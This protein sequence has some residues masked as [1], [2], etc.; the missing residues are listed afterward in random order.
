MASIHQDN[1]DVLSQPHPRATQLHDNGDLVN[2]ATMSSGGTDHPCPPPEARVDA[3]L[4]QAEIDSKKRKTPSVD[5]FV[6]IKKAK[7]TEGSGQSS[8]SPSSLQ[9]PAEV[10]QHIFTFLQPK[11]LGRLL[12]VSRAFNSLLDSSSGHSP[13]ARLSLDTGSLPDLKPEIIWQLSRRR[14]W[15]TMPTPLRGYTELQMWQL[16]C[17]KKCQFHNGIG[18]LVSSHSDSSQYVDEKHDSSQPIW[19][20]ALNSCRPCLMKRITK[21][22]DLL[23]SS[24][25]PSC[26]I[27]ALPFIF[28]GDDMRVILP[29][30]LQAGSLAAP[31]SITKVFLSSHV[32]AI[33][34]EFASVTAMGE[35]TAEEWIKGLEGRGKEHRADSL[36]WERFEISGTFS[37]ILNRLSSDCGQE[38]QIPDE[39]VK[40]RLPTTVAPIGE[41][42]ESLDFQEKIAPAKNNIASSTQLLGSSQNSV[43]PSAPEHYSCSQATIQ[44]GRTREEAEEMKNARRAEIERRAKKLDPPLLPHALALIPSFQA[45]IQITSPFDDTA[46]NVLKPRLL[47]Q[48]K[49]VQR[50]QD[51]RQETSAHAQDTLQHLE[52]SQIPQKLPLET[53]QKLDHDWDDAQAPLRGHISALADFVI[54]E[55]WKN[56]RKVN[57]ESS[58]RFA[59]EVL[60][61]VRKR[62]YAEIEKDDAASRAAGQQPIRDA[63]NG[64][65]TRKLTLENMKW[66]FDVKIKPHT[67]QY[68]RELFYCHVCGFNT[69]L[70][71]LEGVVQHY[72]AKHTSSLSLGNVVVHWRAEWP[73]V[74]PF[75]PE[76]HNLKH[77]RTRSFHHNEAMQNYGRPMP[78]VRYEA[79][80]AQSLY[81]QSHP[82]IAPM[83]EYASPFE[84]HALHHPLNPPL[85]EPTYER[86]GVSQGAVSYLPP[87]PTAPANFHQSHYHMPYQN[88]PTQEAQ[89]PYAQLPNVYHAKLEDISQNAKKIWFTMA[90]MRQLPGPIKM[91]VLIHH[92]CARFRTR[93]SEELPLALFIDGLSTNK[94]MHPLRIINGLRCKAC[95]L[96]LGA[97]TEA[98]QEKDTYSLLQLVRH[99]QDRHL[100]Q[101][102]PDGTPILNWAYDMI[103]LVD[104]SIL[105]NLSSLRNI[106]NWKLSLIRAAF[107]G[108]DFGNSGTAIR[109]SVSKANHQ[110]TKK[111]S[112]DTTMITSNTNART[113]VE[114]PPP[115]CREI[116]QRSSRLSPQSKAENDEK[117][118]NDAYEQHSFDL[119]A[120]LELQLDRQAMSTSSNKPPTP[121]K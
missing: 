58:P 20:F 29:A 34:E 33:Q 77:R 64:P 26:L 52:D 104:L 66:L 15:P 105:S 78:Y 27:P 120:G 8:Q 111:K 13:D 1:G 70:Y 98:T 96:R 28:I 7:V 99:F 92:V 2:S 107:P 71:G 59:A 48:R 94:K 44:R 100:Q 65:Y 97:T 93:F 21:E 95:H 32:T 36:R 45:A 81:G 87:A 79:G 113:K 23:L 18:Q 5:I 10:W 91:F 112:A 35:A 86:L 37:Q 14:F 108:A 109:A 24:S 76:P 83:Q 72:A 68:R 3:D 57:K 88:Y 12:S 74:P 110:A 55:G 73:E 117:R 11:M 47:A 4:S 53:K 40:A 38:N 62:F 118:L 61:Y 31:S 90:P 115:P 17:Q 51:K 6:P 84:S 75:H 101:S 16:A 121:A 67:E 56:G 54:Q 85:A 116:P 46:W 60:V 30:T 22:V 39:R 49:D 89:N 42:N 25:I 114:S 106:D 43:A 82:Y 9:L 19:P 119:M 103:Y 69:K 80:P 50:G 41:R 63:P 102:Y